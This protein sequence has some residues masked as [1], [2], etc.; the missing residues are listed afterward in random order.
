MQ[1]KES[2]KTKGSYCY[3]IPLKD[4]VISYTKCFT[5]GFDR[6][7]EIY[8]QF[9]LENVKAFIRQRGWDQLKSDIYFLNEEEDPLALSSVKGLK[10]Y[11]F[12]EPNK[13]WFMMCLKRHL[14]C[15][16]II[17]FDTLK[18]ASNRIS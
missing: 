18:N 5:E 8:A 6:L 10:G 11:K 12:P 13:K 2:M 3:Q 15:R 7:S 14:I 4:F 16:T 9:T 1:K 17:P